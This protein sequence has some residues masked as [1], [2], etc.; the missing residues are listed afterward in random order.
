MLF[1]CSFSYAFWDFSSWIWCFKA[2]FSSYLPFS[3][4]KLVSFSLFLLKLM[5]LPSYWKHNFL[6]R[7]HSPSNFLL[8]S[9]NLRLESLRSWSERW[10]YLLLIPVWMEWRSSGCIICEVYSSYLRMLTWVGT[11]CAL[12]FDSLLVF[13]MDSSSKKTGHSSLRDSSCTSCRSRKRWN[14]FWKSYCPLAP[15]WVEKWGDWTFVLKFCISNIILWA[16]GNHPNSL[17]AAFLT[18]WHDLLRGCW[19]EGILRGFFITD[20]RYF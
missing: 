19:F 15:L 4:L 14:I 5:P 1:I 9:C 16:T 20:H 2:L 17:F 7:M 11:C 18:F 3:T 12:Q 6:S 13:I 10:L 8:S